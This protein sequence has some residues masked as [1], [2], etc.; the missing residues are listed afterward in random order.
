MSQP[1]GPG[2]DIPEMSLPAYLLATPVAKGTLGA[3]S[4]SLVSLSSCGD[5]VFSLPLG[6]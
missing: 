6:V 3:I 1:S 5:A 4:T 2:A